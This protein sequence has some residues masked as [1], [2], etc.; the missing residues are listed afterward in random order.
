MPYTRK[1]WDKVWRDR[2]IEAIERWEKLAAAFARVDE[3]QEA[4]NAVLGAMFPKRVFH[5]NGKTYRKIS[6]EKQI[7][8]KVTEDKRKFKRN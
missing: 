7:N 2:V 3:I 4:K 1:Y 8:L 6:I 5:H